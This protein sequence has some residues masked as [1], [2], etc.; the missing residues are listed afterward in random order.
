V[1]CFDGASNL[2]QDDR[3]DAGLNQSSIHVDFVVGSNELSVFGSHE[4][5][6]EE[7][8]ISNGEWAFAI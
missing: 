4:D 2:S 7:P 1:S 8:I 3:I 5:G 6:T